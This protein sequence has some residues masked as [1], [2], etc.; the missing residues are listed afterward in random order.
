LLTSV[1]TRPGSSEALDSYVHVFFIKK[2][3]RLLVSEIK[4]KLEERRLSRDASGIDDYFQKNKRKWASLRK[5][6]GLQKDNTHSRRY[7]KPQIQK[8][9][10]ESIPTGIKEAVK[11][12]KKEH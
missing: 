1:A 9:P 5:L 2:N 7:R 8:L 11:E 6:V 12:E 10:E 4:D 3:K